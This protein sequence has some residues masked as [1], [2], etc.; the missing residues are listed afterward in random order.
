MREG[1]LHSVPD[2]GR[3]KSK[4]LMAISTMSVALLMAGDFEKEDWENE[5]V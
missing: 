5:S 4:G 3:L 1:T 2:R